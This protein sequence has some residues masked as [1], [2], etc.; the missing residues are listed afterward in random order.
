MCVPF[1]SSYAT[2]WAQWAQ[3]RAASG[4]SL[5]HSGQGLVDGGDELCQHVFHEG[6]DNGVE[7]RADDD[8]DGQVHNVSAQNEISKAFQHI[9][10]QG[11]A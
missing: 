8:G 3:R 9:F 6:V 1:V 2:G 5:R 11:L 7:G 10:L 4:I